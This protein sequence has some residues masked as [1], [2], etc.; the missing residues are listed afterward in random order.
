[1]S[2]NNSISQLLEQ[3]LELNT[4]SLETFERINEAI[5]SDKQTVT[6]TLYDEK[7]GEMKPIQIPAFGYLKREIERLDTNVKS[8]S[9]LD[10]ANT[11]IRLK[12]G[13]YRRIH[14]SKLKGPSKSLTSLAAP[15][16]FNTKLNDFFEDF[17]NPL[18]TIE[19]NVDNQIQIE[20]ERVYVERYLFD[21]SDVHSIDVFKSNYLQASDIEYANF[22][23]KLSSENIKFHLDSNIIDMPI[24]SLQYSGSLDVVDIVNTQVTQIVDGVTRTKSIKLFTLNKLSYS[25]SSKTMNDTETLKVGDSLAVNSESYSTRYKITSIDSSKSQVEL[26]LIEGFEPVKLGANQLKVYKGIDQGAKIEINIGYNEWQVIFVKPI[27]PVSKIAADEFSPGIGFWSNKLQLALENGDKI[28]LAKYYKDEVADFGQFI[29]ALKVDYIPPAAVALKPSF[30]NV[31]VA[32]FKVVQINKHLT[33]N[34]TTKKIKKL[35]ADKKSAEQSIKRTD[36]AITKKRSILRRKRFKSSVEKN[37][38]KAE[39]SSL[40]NKRADSSKLFSSLVSDIKATADSTQVSAIKPKF[41]ARGFWAVPAPKTY[42][43]EM[44]QDVIQ[45]VVRYRYLSSN[46]KSSTIEQI[47][48]TDSTNQVT[49]TGAFS[50]WIEKETSVKKR[51]LNAETG[52]YEWYF[53]SEEDGQAINFNSLDISLSPGESVEIMVKSVSEAGFPAN[54]VTSDWSEPVKIE[55]PEEYSID[56][57][58]GMVESNERDSIKVEIIS[59]LESKGVYSHVDDSTEDFSHT[60][61]SIA[62][63]FL[64]PEQNPI[65]LYD[66]LVEMQLEIERLKTAASDAVGKLVVKI[67][68]ASGNATAVRANSVVKLFGGYYTEDVSDDTDYKGEIVSK[69]FKI[70][71]SNTRATQ[72]ELVSIIYGSTSSA[73]YVSTDNTL[74]GLGSGNVDAFVVNNTQYTVESKYDLVPVGYQNV[75]DDDLDALNTFN[76]LPSQSSQ[77]RGQFIYS[78]Y[79]NISGEKDLYSVSTGA[80]SSGHSESEYGVDLSYYDL[81]GGPTYNGNLVDWSGITQT[82]APV[83]SGTDGIWDGVIG[84]TATGDNPTNYNDHIYIHKDHPF[85]GVMS[86]ETLISEGYVGMPIAATLQSTDANGHQQTAYQTIIGTTAA[87]TSYR[88]ANKVSFDSGDKYTCGGKS[89]G[90]FLYLSPIDKN[91]FSVDSDNKFGRKRIDVGDENTINV[92]L[93]WQYRMTDY[94]GTGTGAGLVGGLKT[95]PSNITYTK[96]VGIDIQ[97][98]GEDMFSFDVEVTSSY[99]PVGDN[100][101][102]IPSAQVQS[103]R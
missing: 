46:G 48:F 68:D 15:V 84:G 65:S 85:A 96:T 21:D 58:T 9:G 51:R 76:R 23:N 83:G 38:H 102:T 6:I 56:S 54:P 25:D 50:N 74:F 2:A 37:Q 1:M 3:F 12:D 43:D 79:K 94:N 98:Y 100:I 82:T 47:E 57:V 66:K 49:K 60:T 22:K 62:S 91:A 59:D 63:G 19:L 71:L 70:E 55:F 73:A 18:L 42:G 24:R 53:E 87:G 33:D 11:N 32:N 103:F 78:R 97:A 10:S 64:S 101:N 80:N 5:T 67:V 16:A 90:S 13:S 88:R 35:K 93:V 34:A 36:G 26:Q 52:K 69:N 77:T 4:N 41:R 14:T 86:I 30:P 72:L 27:D 81:S 45:F 28:S 8:I 95:N 17:L 40:I 7:T 75:I 44:S 99:K 92:D 61:S 31:D 29:K 89:C 20:T 39:L